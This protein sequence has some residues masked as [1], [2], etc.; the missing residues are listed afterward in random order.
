MLV[1]AEVAPSVLH[2][3][4]TVHPLAFRKDPLSSST[5]A[6]RIA[7]EYHEKSRLARVGMLKLH[8]AESQPMRRVGVA[9]YW[10]EGFRRLAI[11]VLSGSLVLPR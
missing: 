7:C 4:W 11:R 1:L 3:H 9:I 10:S 5:S 6:L 8:K 2:P